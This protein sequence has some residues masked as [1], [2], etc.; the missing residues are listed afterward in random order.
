MKNPKEG[1]AAARTP[2]NCQNKSRPGAQIGR[3]T[4]KVELWWITCLLYLF[5]RTSGATQPTIEE[6]NSSTMSILTTRPP[7]MQVTLPNTATPS[8]LP[9]EMV[10]PMDTVTQQDPVTDAQSATESGRSVT[11]S[12]V[13]GV[14]GRAVILPCSCARAGRSLCRHTAKWEDN[15]EPLDADRGRARDS[16]DSDLD[17]RTLY[18]QQALGSDTQHVLSLKIRGM[19]SASAR[20][21]T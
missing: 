8:Q 18:G 20:T 10:S 5:L 16:M 6:A 4:G 1:V 19:D 2:N 3:K 17:I 12:N 14:L 7:Q 21:Y 11:L 13:E 9:P 15:T